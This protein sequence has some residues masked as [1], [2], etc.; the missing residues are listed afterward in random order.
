MQYAFVPDRNITDPI[1]L[2]E[3]IQ[4]HARKHG[5]ELHQTFMDLKQAF[6]R[7][8]FWA[9][10]LA[11][12]RLGFPTKLKNLLNNMN[13]NSRREVITRDGTTSP[14]TLECGVPQGE[15]LSPLRFIAV[16]DMLATWITLRSN[17]ENPRGKPYGYAI[18]PSQAAQNE[19][20]SHIEPSLNTST[21]IVASMYCDDIQFTTDTFGD[22]QELVGMTQEFMTT[23][24]IPVNAT[25]SFYTAHLPAQGNRNPIVKAPNL[26][27]K[28]IGDATH[29]EWLSDDT[30]PSYL[31]IKQPDEAIRY[32]GVHFTME[33]T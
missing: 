19:A 27:G 4:H 6:D 2:T 13:Q 5:R 15:V 22:M 16:M 23:F 21:R 28:W 17:G 31:T 11:M 30:N 12:N 10:D 25:K 32:L 33:G 20:L 3:M 8:E 9:G 7:L 1:K 14:W 18:N 26:A 24:G 29:G